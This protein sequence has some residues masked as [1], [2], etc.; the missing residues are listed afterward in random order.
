MVTAYIAVYLTFGVIWCIWNSNSRF[1]GFI[2]EKM[3]AD[4]NVI[5]LFAGLAVGSL[6]WPIG[7]FMTIITW[8]TEHL[9]DGRNRHA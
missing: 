9:R 4:D 8:V 5:W 3:Y 2:I 7:L 1:F 6:L